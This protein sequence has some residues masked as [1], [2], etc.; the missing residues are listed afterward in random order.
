MGGVKPSPAKYVASA[1]PIR[2][3]TLVTCP[4]R[5][6]RNGGTVAVAC[7]ICFGGK[8]QLST[9][10]LGPII[11]CL[12]CKGSGGNGPLYTPFACDKHGAGAVHK[13]PDQRRCDPLATVVQKECCIP[14]N[15][16]CK[17]ARHQLYKHKERTSLK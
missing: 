12:H 6:A 17:H 10:M 7:G 4:I 11:S 1:F 5:K 9:L 13:L 15:S 3:V 14:A 16:D 8:A 2:K